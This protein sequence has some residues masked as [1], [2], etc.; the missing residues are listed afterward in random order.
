MKLGY[1]FVLVLSGLLFIG[2]PDA[3]SHRIYQEFWDTG[4]MVL[5]AGLAMILL[6]LPMFNKKPWWLWFV[7]I[8][9]FCLVLG[10]AIEV[11]QLVVGRNFEMKDLL[12][13]LLGGYLG[14]LIVTALQA[15]RPVAIRVSM[16]PLMLL[17]I[18]I[19]LKPLAFVVID[20]FVMEEEFPIL[21]DFETTYELSRWDNNLASLSIDNS[22][23]RYGEKA[24]RIE[25]SAGEYP[26]IT[27][28]DFPRNWQ[29]YV[30]V[31]FSIFNTTDSNL[32]MELKIYDWQHV[33]N[34][35]D[36]SDRF[37]KELTLHPGWND[38][39]IAMEEIQSAPKHRSLELENIASF[40]LFLHELDK[41]MVMYFDSLRLSSS[42]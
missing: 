28:K 32:D 11:V 41:P 19:V 9:V 29:D 38:F 30:A 23:K 7:L 6:S 12:N 27:L 25:F 13:D 10:M 14:L 36:Y 1:I 39:N 24:M 20:E 42:K 15:H 33:K 31:K 3:N 18:A 17:L 35:Y 16:Y 21:A 8:S 2:G 34:G 4:H 37:N 22:Q 26:D 40:S 5:F